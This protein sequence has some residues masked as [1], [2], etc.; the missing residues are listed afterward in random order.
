MY[1]KI[2]EE[3]SQYLRSPQCSTDGEP[4]I[5]IAV[6]LGPLFLDFEPLHQ[7][8]GVCSTDCHQGETD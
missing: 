2:D 7:V 4:L 1:T 6:S 8:T 3:E 5:S